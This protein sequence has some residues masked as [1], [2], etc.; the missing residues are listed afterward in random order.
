MSLG[1]ESHGDSLLSWNCGYCRKDL[2]GQG[3]LGR[4]N[5]GGTVEP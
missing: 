3:A 5:A 4:T 2:V 1:P